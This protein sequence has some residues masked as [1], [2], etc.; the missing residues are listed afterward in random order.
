[1]CLVN[2]PVM[3]LYIFKKFFLLFYSVKSQ[4]VNKIDFSLD[5]GRICL[6][7]CRLNYPALEDPLEN[8]INFGILA[9]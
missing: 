7:L 6:Q 2:R 4:Y 8:T 3:I 5:G 1:M 9:W